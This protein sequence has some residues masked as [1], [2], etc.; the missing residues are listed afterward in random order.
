MGSSSKKVIT[1]LLSGVGFSAPKPVTFERNIAAMVLGDWNSDGKI[2]LATSN[3]GSN[4]VTV[5]L[6]QGGDKLGVATHYPIASSARQLFAFDIHGDGKTDLL[7]PDETGRSVGVLTG[8]GDGTFTAGKPID[9]GAARWIE[10][11][12]FDGNGIVDVAGLG[13]ATMNVLLATGAGT[14]APVR[15]VPCDTRGANFSVGDL[16]GDGHADVLLPDETNRTMRYMLGNGDGTFGSLSPAYPLP[17]VSGT[18]RLVDLNRDGVSEVVI[19]D[20]GH[21]GALGI[22]YGVKDCRT[23]S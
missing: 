23:G 1:F 18:A 17:V 6:G 10:L 16:D 21:D 11:G 13:N 8:V 20:N 9:L 19:L 2:D 7:W 3:V 12:D 5:V 22:L 14:F 15:S 4:D